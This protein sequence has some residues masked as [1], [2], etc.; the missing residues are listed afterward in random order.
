V[1]MA[2]LIKGIVGIFFRLRGYPACLCCAS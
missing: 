1:A 2:A